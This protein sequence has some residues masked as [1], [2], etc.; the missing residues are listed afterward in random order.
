[1]LTKK[2]S[3]NH[4]GLFKKK[5]KNMKSSCIRKPVC[6][7]FRNEERTGRGD[8]GGECAPLS[9]S[10]VTIQNNIDEKFEDVFW[11][12]ANFAVKMN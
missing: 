4:R 10:V 3:T 2:L 1:M 9:I 11:K 8:R 7:G 12:S 5:K 6:V